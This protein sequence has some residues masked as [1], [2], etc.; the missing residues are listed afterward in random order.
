[1]D[2]QIKKQCSILNEILILTEP[3][4][5]LTLNGKG[6]H[7]APFSNSLL[8]TFLPSL[9]SLTYASLKILG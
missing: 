8:E 3:H 9:V 5:F 2:L 7:F 1:M 6:Q 4:D